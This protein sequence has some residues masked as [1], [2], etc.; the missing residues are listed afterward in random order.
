MLAGCLIDIFTPPS[1]T[2]F[3]KSKLIR[4][5]H[6]GVVTQRAWLTSS[7]GPGTHV[8]NSSSTNNW[9]LVNCFCSQIDSYDEMK[10]QIG[11]CRNNWSVVTLT[12][13]WPD[14]II[15]LYPKA[16]WILQDKDYES[17]NSWCRY[18]LYVVSAPVLTHFGPVIPYGDKDQGQHFQMMAC[19]PAAPNHYL[20]QCWLMI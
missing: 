18:D 12:K 5:W 3:S 4:P 7:L 9:N 15:I 8:T 16:K 10:S 1:N 19:C 11:I 13:L 14:L 6:L 20:N 2:M 17:I